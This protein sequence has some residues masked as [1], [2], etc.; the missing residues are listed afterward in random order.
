M[1][2]RG[3]R[4][5]T[6]VVTKAAARI[7]RFSAACIIACVGLM[8]VISIVVAA[9]LAH[10]Q[11]IEARQAY[12]QQ[13]A[14]QALASSERTADE[15]AQARPLIA[16]TSARTGARK[17]CSDA[18]IETMRGIDLASPLLQAVGRIEGNTI[19]CSSIAGQRRIDLG[20]PDLV[21]RAG[22]RV[23]LN[24][25]PMGGQRSYLAIGSGALVG[26]IHKDLALSMVELMPGAAVSSFNWSHK[27]MLAAR[28]PFAPAWL[29]ADLA[30]G[31]SWRVHG[32]VLAVARSQHYD[33]G[34]V[35]AAPLNAVPRLPLRTAALLLPIDILAGLLLTM[36]ITRIAEAKAS[37]P[38]MIAGA[39]KRGEFFITYQPIVALESGRTVGAEALI[40]WRR[41]NG[42]VIAPDLF[43]P[44]AEQAGSIRHLTA[45]V[46]DL[47]ARDIGAHI[48]TAELSHLSVNFSADDM[49]SPDMVENILAFSRQAGIAM[50]NIVIEATERSLIDIE[51]S[52]Q[53]IRR[54][55]AMGVR[56]AI[57]D[58]G[59]GY[60]SLGYLAQLEIDM[61]KID[62][63]FVQAL[64]TGSAASQV[65]ERVI[66]MA[67]D[68]KLE[69]IAEGVETRGQIE[70]LKTLQVDL[71]QGYYFA[72]PMPIGELQKRL[73]TEAGLAP[74]EMAPVE[75]A[76]DTAPRLHAGAR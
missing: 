64:G 27:V 16:A 19:L 31:S 30:G 15:L 38:A 33:L 72:F 54:L 50:A 7:R 45:H 39:M 42:E 74:V 5:A 57:D 47:V 18:D 69:I 75:M 41:P 25:R 63:L 36:A 29:R 8:V 24:V 66:E 60:S 58:F 21:S 37:L 76:P 20:P 52:S 12:A 23:W 71:A 6:K 34:V 1:R 43:I 61:L 2:H 67:R 70:R 11:A 35:A 73:R 48:P 22:A 14:R 26:I 49:Q 4:V 13:L 44:V 51:L 55:R 59:T 40:R 10:R 32:F 28:G 53:A 56:I 46:L 65:A 9:A 62:R 17:A 3:S 68:L